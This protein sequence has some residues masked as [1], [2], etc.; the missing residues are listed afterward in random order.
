MCV[1][2]HNSNGTSVAYLAARVKANKA[3]YGMIFFRNNKDSL[4][5]C[6]VSRSHEGPA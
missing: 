4:G 1:Q 6:Q 2:L 5:H 3:K